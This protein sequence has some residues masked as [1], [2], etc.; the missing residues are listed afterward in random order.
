MRRARIVS[1]FDAPS[2]KARAL[3]KRGIGASDCH[4]TNGVG[5]FVTVFEEELRDQEHMLE[6]LRAGR[7]HAAQGLPAGELRPYVEEPV[8]A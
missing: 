5:Y 4:S 6:Q 8:E 3:G 7:F 2:V 1:G